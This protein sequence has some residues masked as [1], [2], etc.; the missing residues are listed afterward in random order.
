MRITEEQIERLTGVLS[1]MVVT[2]LVVATVFEDLGINIV[3]LIAM[4]PSVLQELL[5][6]Y[7]VFFLAC[8]WLLLIFVV[9]EG[10]VGA[11]VRNRYPEAYRSRYLPAAATVLFILSFLSF[12]TFRRFLDLFLMVCSPTVLLTRGGE[13]A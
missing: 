8:H 11:Y 12:L 13:H 6:E 10:Y 3:Q 2:V 7:F 5:R 1:N 9:A 4:A